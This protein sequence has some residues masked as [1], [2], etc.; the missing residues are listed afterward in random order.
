MRRVLLWLPVIAALLLSFRLSSVPG[1]EFATPVP[2]YVAHMI[3]YLLLGL[4][5]LRGFNDGMQNRPD[6]RT[7]LWAVLFC[8]VW[9]VA[10]EFHQSFVP[11]RD[12]SA[13]DVL[14]D[15]VGAVAACGVFVMV[16]PRVASW[17]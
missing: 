1:T 8:L 7:M 13:G 2:D 5:V 16:R 4:L 14:S 10:D 11:G 17:L 9:A 15:L 6:A 12:A 3:Q